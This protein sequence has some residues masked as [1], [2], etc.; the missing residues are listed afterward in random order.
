MSIEITTA[1]VKQYSA[2]VFHLV[3]QSGSRLLPHVRRESINSEESFFDRIGTATA[4]KKTSRH[5]EIVYDNTPHTRRRVISEDYYYSDLVDN[6]DKLRILINPESEYAMAARNA[7]GRAIDDEIIVQALGNAYGSKDGSSAVALPN[8]QKI[9]AH[10]G[11]TAAT[12][13]Q[14]LNVRT[15]RAVK[16]KFNANEAGEEELFMAISAEQLDDLLA[17]TE[18]TSS[19]FAAV[20][21]LVHGDV[22][23]FMGFM[24]IRTERLNVTA[25]T[26]T[27]N[28]FNGSVGAGTDTLPAGSRRCIAWQKMGILLATAKEVQGRVDEIPTKHHAKQVYACMAVGGTRMEEERVVEVICTEV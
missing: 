9:A 14:R 12:L 25:G 10:D 3:Q 1:M 7:L 16:K 8:S 18:V 22:D 24:F 19:D 20:K 23:T 15:L 21:A 27:Y 17:E 26:T 13:G 6:E 28:I 11:A 4:R 5:S 2:N